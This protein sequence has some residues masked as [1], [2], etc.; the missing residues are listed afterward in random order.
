MEIS[1]EKTP[2]S[3]TWLLGISDTDQ[4]AFFNELWLKIESAHTVGFPSALLIFQAS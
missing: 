1:R 2:A 4:I 3:L